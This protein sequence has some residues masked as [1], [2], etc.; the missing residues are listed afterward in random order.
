MET[1]NLGIL[2]VLVKVGSASLIFRR[3]GGIYARGVR[4]AN[5]ALGLVHLKNKSVLNCKYCEIAC[6][7]SK[8][9]T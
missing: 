4:S 2:R 1:S 9:I 7:N 5:W 8:M 6:G 3:V